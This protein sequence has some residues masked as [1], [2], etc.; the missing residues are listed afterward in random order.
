MVQSQADT[1]QQYLAELDDDW[2]RDTLLA[3]RQ[4][5][6]D[7]APELEESM[8]YKMLGY[9]TGDAALLHLNAQ[10]NHVGLYVGDAEKIDPDGVL[11]DGLDVGKG[12]IRFKKTTV[13]P[14][15]RIA[16][17]IDRYIQRWRSGDDVDC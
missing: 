9:G 11:L 2:R 12:C 7:A 4:L 10:K 14:D 15:T 5:V 17:F 16:D 8:S 13:V 6:L 3:L 1:P